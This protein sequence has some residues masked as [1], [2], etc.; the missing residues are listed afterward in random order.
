MSSFMKFIQT[1]LLGEVSLGLKRDIVE[2]VLGEPQ[3]I[4]VAST[5]YI[6]KYGSFPFPAMILTP[7]FNPFICILMKSSNFHT[8]CSLKAGYPINQ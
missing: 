6:L 5:P 4:S 8:D 3:D 7:L 2:R 1:G